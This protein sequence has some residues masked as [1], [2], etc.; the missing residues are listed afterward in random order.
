MKKLVILIAIFT[1]SYSSFS[2]M[3]VKNNERIGVRISSNYD[4][5]VGQNID[6]S[7]SQLVLVCSYEFKHHGIYFGPQNTDVLQPNY[8]TGVRQRNDSWG[9][10][11]GYRYTFQEARKKL[12]LFTQINFSIFQF[13]LQEPLVG[14]PYTT[15]H[16]NLTVENSLTLGLDYK[17][18][19]DIHVFL[20]SGMGSSKGFFL[21]MDGF[22]LSSYAGV[23]YEL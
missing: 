14:P 9:L 7:V 5:E 6:Y 10:N 12:K 8:Y 20:G 21:L 11:C 19:K 15:N 16:K 1:S 13:K 2:Q 3:N 17:I 23:E 18:T 4:T 22:N